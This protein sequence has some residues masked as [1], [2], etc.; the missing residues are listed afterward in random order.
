[1]ATAPPSSPPCLTIDSTVLIA[2]CAKEAGRHPLAHAELTTYA[3]QG[4]EF[5]APGNVVAECL[6]VLCRKL[7]DDGTLSQADHAAAVLRKC[8][9]TCKGEP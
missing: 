3:N 5:Y 4:Y 7:R 6:Y 1:M 8:R 9:S 2:I